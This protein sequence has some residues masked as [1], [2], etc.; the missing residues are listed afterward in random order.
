M[1]NVKRHVTVTPTFNSH[2]SDITIQFI[3]IQQLLNPPL[4]ITVLHFRTLAFDS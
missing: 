3:H 4:I 1:M 2:Q